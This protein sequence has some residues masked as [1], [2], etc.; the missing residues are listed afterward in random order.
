MKNLFKAFGIFCL[1]GIA[2]TII[3]SVVALCL[4]DWSSSL[5]GLYTMQTLSLVVVF[6]LSA[7]WGIRATEH[8]DP[9]RLVGLRTRLNLRS[10]LIVVALAFVS[11]LLVSYTEQLNRQLPLPDVLI[12][13]EQAAAQLTDRLLNTSSVWCLLL[14][15]V[16]I[17]G[18]PALCEEFMFR[19]WIQRRL[20][21][22]MNHHIA[23]WVTALIFSAVHLQFLGFLPRFLLGAVL[24]Y[25]YF[26]THSLWASVLLHFTNNA[27]AA[28]TAFLVFNNVITETPSTLPLAIASLALLFTLLF[29]LR[30]R[31]NS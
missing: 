23:I 5:T 22:Q 13:M 15:I 19:G 30:K 24:G 2:F 21:E 31:N 3:Q 10:A 16:I 6:F 11:I 27:L 25:A 1:L 14:N 18:V 20:A 4:H 12:L 17:A 7:Y 29:Y 8:D 26:Y 28:L 9:L